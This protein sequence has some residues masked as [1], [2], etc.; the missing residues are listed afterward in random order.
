MKGINTIFFSFLLLVIGNTF[1]QK[2]KYNRIILENDRT[3]VKNQGKSNFNLGRQADTIEHNVIIE[4]D[5]QM[6]FIDLF[7]NGNFMFSNSTPAMTYEFNLPAAHYDLTSLFFEHDKPYQCSYF[8]K[9]FNLK[10]DTTIF[11][12]LNEAN[13][14][15]HYQFH[16]IDGDSLVINQMEFFF[17]WI[18]DKYEGGVGLKFFSLKTKIFRVFYNQFPAKDYEREWF[19]K[20]KQPLNDGDLYMLNGMINNNDTST[21]VSNDPGNY[22]H[23]VFKYNL[24][25]FSDLE[26]L[27]V[28]FTSP[29]SGH[30][31]LDDPDYTL[32]LEIS[33][34]QGFSAP[35]EYLTSY[36]SQRVTNGRAEGSLLISPRLRINNNSILGITAK[37]RGK[38]IISNENEVR[39]GFSPLYWY[40]KLENKKDSIIITGSWD[41]RHSQ[42]LFLSQTNDNLPQSKLVIR[43]RNDENL[44]IEK[45]VQQSGFS[46]GYNIG[47]LIFPLAENKYKLSVY[48]DQVEVAGIKGYTIV[49]TEF[50]LRMNDKN[51]PYISMFQI[52]SDGNVNNVLDSESE[53]IIRMRV[54]DNDLIEEVKLNYIGDSEPEWKELLIE[55][56]DDVYEAELPKLSNNY[57]SLRIEACDVS[58]NSIKVDMEPAFKYNK[59]T[60]LNEMDNKTG[61]E[62]SLSCYPN[63]FNH[64]TILSIKPPKNFN[65]DISI[66]IFNI[67]GERKFTLVKNKLIAK[68]SSLKWKAVDNEGN[69]LPSGIYIIQMKGGDKIICK[70]L[71]LLK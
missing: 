46:L 38:F 29:G 70:K 9:Q 63:P 42:Y 41:F 4:A 45:E 60:S 24:S 2:F 67:L 50:D 51:P 52:L 18:D 68:E 53:N 58:G 69:N 1:A 49:D 14:E 32:P 39:L 11:V 25:S 66:N 30:Y 35:I 40:G 17:I 27:Q 21:V 44:L 22:Q 64:E 31:F 7:G 12:K 65:E 48:C 57:Y 23:V 55:L 10:S 28:S 56:K 5:F 71:L 16:Q 62:F 34:Y 36:F 8:F 47:D 13:K 33:V 6:Q 59:V 15:K 43:I 3:I 37:E 26:H 20:G 54:D 19:L 61:G